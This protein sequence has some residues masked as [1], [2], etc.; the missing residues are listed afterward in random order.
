MKNDLYPPVEVPERPTW[1]DVERL[2]LHYPAAHHAVTLVNRGDLTREEALIRLVF[3][4]ANAF[5]K[6]FSAEVERRMQD[7]SVR[8]PPAENR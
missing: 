6:L 8:Y 5:Q 4:L 1:A 2:S 3:A 7:T